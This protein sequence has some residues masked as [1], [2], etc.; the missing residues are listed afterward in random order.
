M[1]NT[2]FLS[3][4]AFVGC[5]G[6]LAIYNS[7]KVTRRTSIAFFLGNRSLGFWM[8]GSSLFL[9]NMSANQF[10]GENEFVY[11]T[12]MSVMAWGMSAVFAMIMVAEFLMPVYLRIGAVTTPD[13]LEL[14]F[15]SHTSPMAPG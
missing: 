5:A 13:F 11:T 1:N 8:I 10:I 14:R 4:L 2:I 3:F 15:D 9:T 7:R 6:L 12:N